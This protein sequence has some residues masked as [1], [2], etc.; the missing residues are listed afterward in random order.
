[1]HIIGRHLN[2]GLQKLQQLRTNGSFEVSYQMGMSDK[3]LFEKTGSSDIR[4]LHL[5]A[6]DR[7]LFYNHTNRKGALLV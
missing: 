7:D 2:L 5:H 6:G 4:V 1:M 3:M